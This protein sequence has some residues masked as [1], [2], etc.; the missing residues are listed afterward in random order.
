[1]AIKIEAAQR[2][3]AA[4]SKSLAKIKAKQSEV[5]ALVKEKFKDRKGMQETAEPAT[6]VMEAVSKLCG[7]KEREAYLDD[8]DWRTYATFSDGQ[9]IQDVLRISLK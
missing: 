1:M 9:N 8:T 4:K 2:L 6:W 3:L 7:L 5:A